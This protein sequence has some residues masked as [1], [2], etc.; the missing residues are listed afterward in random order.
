MVSLHLDLLLNVVRDPPAGRVPTVREDRSDAILRLPLGGKNGDFLASFVEQV[1]AM[2]LDFADG[3]TI[4]R[5]V[6]RDG[7]ILAEK[8][9]DCC[10]DQQTEGE[11]DDAHQ[12]IS[13]HKK[14]QSRNKHAR[15]V[16]LDFRLRRMPSA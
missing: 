5:Y 12:E 11:A 6:V 14:A 2:D 9:H 4:G 10:D 7:D 3:M 1:G 13:P 15:P 8:D 16:Q